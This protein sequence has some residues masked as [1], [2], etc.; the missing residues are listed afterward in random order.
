MIPIIRS[1]GTGKTAMVVEFKSVAERVGTMSYTSSL[2]W[3]ELWP[4]PKYIS[5]LGQ[6]PKCIQLYLLYIYLGGSYR[7][8]FP[9]VHLMDSDTLLRLRSGLLPKAVTMNTTHFYIF[10]S[11]HIVI[12]EQVP[13]HFHFCIFRIQSMVVAQ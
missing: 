9:F 2:S 4:S 13:H 8:P 11:Y 10:L 6:S 1:S 12:S 3:L 7:N 5:S